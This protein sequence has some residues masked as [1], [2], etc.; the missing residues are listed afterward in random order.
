MLTHLVLPLWFGR[1]VGTTHDERKAKKSMKE[2]R[3]AAELKALIMRELRKHPEWHDIEDVA[4]TSAARP[5]EQP[6]WGAAFTMS[7][8]RSAPEGAFRFARELG[9]KFDLG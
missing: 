9:A 4:I 7:G 8:P 6:N 1:S 5:R 2:K 3:S